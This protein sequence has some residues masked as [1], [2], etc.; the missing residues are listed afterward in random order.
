MSDF[1]KF[2]NDILFSVTPYTPEDVSAKVA[3]INKKVNQKED[4]A[5]KIGSI[6]TESLVFSSEIAKDFAI[7]YIE[8]YHKWLTQN[9]DLIPKDK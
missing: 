4:F 8:E 3:S 2:K 7:K 9:Y 6:V 5:S 1:E